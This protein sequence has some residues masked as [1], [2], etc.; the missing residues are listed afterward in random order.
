MGGG[1]T[2]LGARRQMCGDTRLGTKSKKG[3]ELGSGHHGEGKSVPS[4]KEIGYSKGAMSSQARDGD[5]S[6]KVLERRAGEKKAEP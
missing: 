5:G 6:I 2:G 4:A 1:Q 3:G